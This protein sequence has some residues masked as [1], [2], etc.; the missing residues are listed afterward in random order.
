LTE[1]QYVEG[2]GNMWLEL[3]DT[4]FM[5]NS[6]FYIPRLKINLLYVREITSQ[7]PHLGVILF[8][9]GQ[10]DEEIYS[11]KN[12]RNGIYRSVG[13]DIAESHVW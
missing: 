4:I 6:V 8:C 11:I 2:S 10:E 9:G 5:L 1:A 7:F 3:E 13:S 12:K